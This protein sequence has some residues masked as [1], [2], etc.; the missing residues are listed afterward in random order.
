MNEEQLQRVLCPNLP[1]CNR[2]SDL[3]SILLFI[4]YFV[5][6]LEIEP[7]HMKSVSSLFIHS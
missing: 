5:H 3:N 2:I 1:S 6:V 4:L 7:L